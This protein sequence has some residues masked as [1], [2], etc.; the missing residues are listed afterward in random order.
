MTQLASWF[1]YDPTRRIKRSPRQKSKIVR[2]GKEWRTEALFRRRRLAQLTG[3]HSR[4]TLRQPRPKLVLL[5]EID[6]PALDRLSAQARMFEPFTRQFFRE[7]GLR[8]GMRV[9][10]VGCGSGDVAAACD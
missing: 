5:D 3:G 7:A 9:L 6:Q 10:D 2:Q 8:L 4:N 1:R